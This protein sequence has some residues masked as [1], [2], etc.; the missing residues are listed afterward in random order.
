[1]SDRTRIG[2]VAASS[3]VPPL[4]FQIGVEFLRD[5]FFDVKVHPQVLEQHFTFAGTDERRAAGLFEYARDPLLDVVWMARGGYGA[6][7]LLPILDELTGRHGVPPK[8]LLVGYSDVTVLHEYVRIRWG[9]ETLHAPMPAAAN[10]TTMPDETIE[11][12]FSCVRIGGARFPWEKAQLTF[13]DIK[14]KETIDAELIGGNLTLWTSLM[15]TAYQPIVDGVILFFEDLGEAAYRIDRY[16]TQ[17]DQT[18][19]FDGCAAIILGDFTKCSDENNDC[20]K[21]LQEGE[22]LAD[23]KARL[24]TRPRVPLRRVYSLDESI[25]EIFGNISRKHRIPIAKGLPVGHGPNFNPL[26]LGV[27]YRLSPDGHLQL[28]FRGER[29]LIEN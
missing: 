23:V 12:I 18:G 19:G 21:P 1:M 11:A 28:P 16:I 6:A 7:R 10:F 20:A 8:K 3:V 24:A 13:L 22:T 26:P 27:E 4:E 17:I 25:Q 2:I 15:G 5:H 29:L 9:W 14:P